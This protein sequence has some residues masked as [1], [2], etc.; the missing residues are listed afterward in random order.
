MT[1]IIVIDIIAMT[2]QE[3][4]Y[5]HGRRFFVQ[6][7]LFVVIFIVLMFLFLFLKN[8]PVSDA[9]SFFRVFFF[10]YLC[11]QSMF[12]FPTK[13]DSIFFSVLFAHVPIEIPK[14][15]SVYTRCSSLY[16]F[17]FLLGSL[18]LFV[19]ENIIVNLFI[20]FCRRR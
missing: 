9:F 12:S 13:T 4:T 11:I 14:M 1:D 5:K 6:S 19:E 17:L 8:L 3:D 2:H 15:P 18:V 16:C 7:L 10:N 20:F